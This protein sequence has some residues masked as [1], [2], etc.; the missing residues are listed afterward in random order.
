MVVSSRKHIVADRVRL[1]DTF[2]RR[3]KGLMGV[4]HLVPGEGLLLKN[5]SSIHSFFMK[6]TI[7]AVYLSNDFTVLYIE[8]LPP[9]RIGKNVKGAKHVLELSS[10]PMWLSVGDTLTLT[11]THIEQELKSISG[12]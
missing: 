4:R 3:F 12:G 8:T 7:D 11:P 1:A 2:F 5:C 10:A 9:W 6:I